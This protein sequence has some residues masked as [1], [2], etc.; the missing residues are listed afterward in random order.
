MDWTEDGPSISTRAEVR[1]LVGLGLGRVAK[2]DD[3]PL[4]SVGPRLLGQV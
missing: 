1:E 3:G 2:T 4:T